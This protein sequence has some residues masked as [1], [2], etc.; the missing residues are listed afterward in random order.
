[1]HIRAEKSPSGSLDTAGRGKDEAVAC[2]VETDDLPSDVAV[3]L[4]HRADHVAERP[5]RRSPPERLRVCVYRRR[6]Q[7]QANQASTR[8]LHVETS[9]TCN[10][11]AATCR[12]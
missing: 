11:A 7:E 2:R 6:K 5:P 12:G 10:C 8:E 9:W 3:R 4:P 1:R